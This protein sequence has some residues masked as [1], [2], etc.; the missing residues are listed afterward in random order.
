VNILVC[1]LLFVI[2]GA[3]LILSVYVIVLVLAFNREIL[4]QMG[5][6]RFVSFLR[7]HEESRSHLDFIFFHEFLGKNLFHGF[8]QMN[9][10]LKPFYRRILC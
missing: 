10:L 3:L 8:E 2:M 9:V 6:I 4:K 7:I 1:P 5:E